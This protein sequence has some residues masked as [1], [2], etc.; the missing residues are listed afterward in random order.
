MRDATRAARDMNANTRLVVATETLAKR[1]ELS[2][3]FVEEVQTQ[4][5]DPQVRAMKQREAVANLLEALVEK[6]DDSVEWPEGPATDVL[7]EALTSLSDIKGIS[8]AMVEK[9][10]AH[11]YAQ[12]GAFVLGVLEETEEGDGEDPVVELPA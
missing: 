10:K 6:T 11:V 8:P 9:I 3:G 12:L 1:F 7:D 5:G 4:S 2:A